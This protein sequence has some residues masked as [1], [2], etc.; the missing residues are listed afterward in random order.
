MKKK[1]T[2]LLVLSIAL[3]SLNTC[4]PERDNPWDKFAA[5]NPD[6]WAPNNL[7][8]TVNNLNSLSLSW[9]SSPS[10]F[11]G[12]RIGRKLDS[13]QWMADIA[14]IAPTINIYSDTQVDLTANSYTYKVYAYA[15]ENSSSSIEKHIQPTLVSTSEIN[16][17]TLYIAK[18]GG[19]VSSD[20]LLPITARGVVWSTSQ[21]PTIPTKEAK[22]NETQNDTLTAKSDTLWNNGNKNFQNIE[23]TAPD[24]ASKASSKPIITLTQNG[25]YTTDGSGTG[26]WVSNIE[27]LQPATTYFVRAYATSGAG[28]AYGNEQTFTTEVPTLPTLTTNSISSITVTTATCGGN[29]T[30]DGGAI[31]TARGAIWSTAQNPTT[32]S[33]QGITTN[34]TGIGTFTSKL[35]NLQPGTVYYVRSYATNSVGTSYGSQVS[36]TTWQGSVTDIEG[37]VYRTTIIGNQEWMAENLRTTKYNNSSSIPNVT[38]NSEWQILS[39]PAYCW[40]NNDQSTYGNLYG[41]LYNWYAVNTGNLCPSGWRIP[42]DYEWK[43]LEGT[44]DSQYDVGDPVWDNDGWRGYDAS[45]R[46]KA[47]NGWSNNGNGTDDYDFSALPGGY[48]LYHGGFYNVGYFSF[49][50]NSTGIGATNAWARALSGE[51]SSV[52]RFNYIISDGYSVRCLRDNKINNTEK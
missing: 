21:N 14:T 3:L 26:T 22:G 11:E 8:I 20:E 51:I 49:W 38:G 46:L 44:V 27:G 48:R 52:L 15:G 39:T 18:G 12:F 45:T 31:I 35:T 50:W 37:N 40:Y 43:N 32:T 23:L 2:I 1:H 33:N 34:G 25:G 5:I 30:S 9:K 10:N 4:L 19:N 7:T 24:N 29:I 47:T 36:F 42:T 6:A 13:E 17:I 28:T 41:A 16:N